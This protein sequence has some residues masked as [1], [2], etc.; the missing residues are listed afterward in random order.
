[1]SESDLT[2]ESAEETK[3][4]RYRQLS[5]DIA[6]E[7]KVYI[8][9]EG[10]PKVFYNH[11][12]DSGPGSLRHAEGEAVRIAE[13]CEGEATIM[14]VPKASVEIALLARYHGVVI[15]SLDEQDDE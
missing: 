13:A 5:E 15:H 7:D 2:Q 4:E 14:C 12:P 3:R 9:F 6:T 10:R 11:T 8:V 1:M